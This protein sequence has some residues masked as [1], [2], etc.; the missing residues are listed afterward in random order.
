MK[1]V[2]YGA[3][4]KE[5]PGLIDKEGKLRD[6]SGVIPDITSAHLSSAALSKLAKIKTSTLPL[7][8]GKPRYGV[9]LADVGKFLAIGLNY[10]DHAAEA[11]MPCPKEPIIFFKADT[12]LSGPNDPVMLPKGSKKSDWEVELGVVIGKKARYVSKK[13]ALKHVAGYCLVNDVSERE[14]QIERGGT[15]DKGKGCDTFGPVGPWLVTADEIKNPQK[16]G[17]WLDVNGKRFQT[18][19][20]KT[21]IFDVQTIVSYVSEF[22]TLM[23]GDII[24]TGTPPGVGMGVKP[25]PRY[26]KAGDVMTLGIEGLVEQRQ[27]VV[28]FKK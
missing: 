1:L 9:P 25:K 11:G 16:L 28:A 5:K 20:T 3:K 8:K 24:T 6:L 26:L 13:D 22:M 10:S 2:R 21:M 14:Y 23:P 27:E 19:N 15:W 18:G 12:S 17:M 7:V 4:G